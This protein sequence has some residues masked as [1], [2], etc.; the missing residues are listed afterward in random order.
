MRFSVSLFRGLRFFQSVHCSP[1][2]ALHRKAGGL[3]SILA[4][5]ILV[6]LWSG[7][8]R[9]ASPAVSASSTISSVVT[10]DIQEGIEKHIADRLVRGN[11]YFH[12]VMGDRD[13]RLKLVRVHTEFLS[14]LAPRKHFACVDLVDIRGDVY[15]LDFF[16]D[17]DPGMMTVTK[18]DVH[19]INGQ[20]YYSWKQNPDRTWRRVPV[21]QAPPEQLGVILGTDSFEFLYRV[22][23]PKLSGQARMWLPFAS[24]GPFQTVRLISIKAPGTRRLIKDR[25]HGNRVLFLTFGS[26]ASGKTVEIR[27]AV[28]RR[29]KGIQ[30]A[31][32]DGSRFLKPDRLVPADLQFERIARKVVDGK[33]TDLEKARALYDH[34]IDGM[35]YMKFG[36]GWGKGDA[37]YAC[38]ARSGNC[39][40]YHSY[41]IALARSIGIPARF[42]I[43]AAIPSDRNYGV[44]D[45]YHCW[46]EFYADGNWWPVD[47]SEADKYSTLATYYFGH[48]PANRLEL[49]RGRDLVVD[50][51]PAG[52]PINF[53]AY[54]VLEVDDRPIQ[55][56]VE[57]SFTR[58][59][60]ER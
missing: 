56:K 29:E 49:S 50:P 42:S 58:P 6:G 7:T 19:K 27:Y 37:L 51:A 14:N 18:T 43:G 46:A 17:G 57:F 33:K 41:F 4:I 12:H 45:G 52:G 53:L 2:G 10:A 48:Y 13:L 8:A 35:R 11:G 1:L 47:I 44:I 16:L 26:E 36:P 39:T 34:V 54:P 28:R 38:S 60:V 9:G 23:L 55:A 40:D 25:E 5:V 30:A 3:C 59:T 24:T 31:S 32:S 22:P 21:E 20:P 15:D